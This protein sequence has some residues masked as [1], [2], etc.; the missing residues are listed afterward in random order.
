MLLHEYLLHP[1][2]EKPDATALICGENRFSYGEIAQAASA[3]GRSLRKHG[4]LT[5]DR[6]VLY[7]GNGYEAV[8]G[9]FGTLMA[10]GCIVPVGAVTPIERVAH[11]VHHS[12]AQVVLAPGARSAEIRSALTKSGRLPQLIWTDSS[13]CLTGEFLFSDVTRSEGARID[14][15]IAFIDLD[16]A[17]IIYT[18]GSSGEPKGVT[19]TH[20]SIDTGVESIIGYLQNSADDVILSVLQL[21]F[22]YGLLQLLATFRTGATLVLERG[23]GYP[24][25]VVKQFNRHHVTGFAG[26]P[27]IWAMILQMPDLTPR[28]FETVRYITN[29]AAAMPE[30]FV[31]R[32]AK[33][34][35]NA[36]IFLMHGLTECLRT[37]YLPPEEVLSN[38]TSIGRAMRNVEL[39]LEDEDGHRLGSGQAGELV[40]RG[41]TLM[42]GYWNDPSGTAR[43]LF[44]GRHP[45][46]KVLHTGDLFRMDEKGYFYFVARKD[47]MIKCRGEKVSPVEV[48]AVIYRLPEVA[49]CRI[50]GIPN[51]LLGNKIRAEI[52]LRGGKS[53]DPARVKAHCTEHLEPYKIP[54]DVE[55]VQSLPKTEGGKIIRRTSR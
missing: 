7:L 32:L 40:V 55:F 25:E 27:T 54:H 52:V 38:P 11:V 20:R 53:L 8:V 33:L 19:H 12:D 44:P 26:S 43:M 15:T 14:D 36:R 49:E 18:S 24:Y 16:L 10:G 6:V 21:N 29:A 39:W 51:Q 4:L 30:P 1:A 23:F 35:S 2:R 13:N 46:E 37:G 17:A 50:I 3:L 41:S 28:D 42:A 22:S 9:I 34:F 31:P 45:W 47:D 48:E 5:G